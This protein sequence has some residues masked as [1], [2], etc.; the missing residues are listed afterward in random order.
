M[1]HAKIEPE[2]VAYLALN[3]TPLAEAEMRHVTRLDRK[4][5]LRRSEQVWV[6]HDENNHTLLVA[7]IFRQSQVGVP[8]LWM[9]LCDEFS[10]DL[11]HNMREAREKLE[12]L[13]DLY[14]WVKVR[15]DARYPAGQKFVRLLGFT[16][17]YRETHGEREYIHYEV[18]RGVRSNT[19]RA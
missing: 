12:E 3:L 19:G 17:F 14:P 18:R 8:E 2:E 1:Y 13:L 15:V 16:E 7:G 4:I 11:L 9:L 5:F 6:L 10:R